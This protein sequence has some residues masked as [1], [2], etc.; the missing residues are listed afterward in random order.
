METCDNHFLSKL[1]LIMSHLNY[2]M[3]EH[4]G[5]QTMIVKFTAR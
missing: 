1:E 4:I 5:N 2:Y 3:D